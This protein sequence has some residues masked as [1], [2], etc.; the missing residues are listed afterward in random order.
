MHGSLHLL[1]YFIC[2]SFLPLPCS[3]QKSASSY[4][5][6]ILTGHEMDVFASLK[7]CQVDPFS[8]ELKP[9][10]FN[11]SWISGGEPLQTN[12]IFNNIIM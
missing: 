1:L 6:R 4:F 2:T 3:F 8:E 10:E 9:Q 12:I 7:F 11:N 5:V